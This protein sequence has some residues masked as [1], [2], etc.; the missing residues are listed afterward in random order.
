VPTQ[1]PPDNSRSTIAA[2]IARARRWAA[3]AATRRQELD[4]A[5]DAAV[6]TEQWRF[7][8]TWECLIVAYEAG[9]PEMLG[10]TSHYSVADERSGWKRLF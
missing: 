7:S 8:G 5:I 3:R 9:W 2:D 4:P 6:A 10:T 1:D